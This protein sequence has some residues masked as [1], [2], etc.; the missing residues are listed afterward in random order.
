MQLKQKL[1]VRVKKLK[2]FTMDLVQ[3]E[4]KVK[5]T[6]ADGGKV[7]SDLP[8]LLVHSWSKL[9]A[10]HAFLAFDLAV[11]LTDAARALSNLARQ[12]KFQTLGKQR[13][14]MGTEVEVVMD[15]L[16]LVRGWGE[17]W[18]LLDAAE[19]DGTWRGAIAKNL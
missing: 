18:H 17:G 1:V 9:R 11:A 3:F 6:L 14:R 16:G 13:E 19:Y 10:Q 4:S 8:E 5:S 15:P 12:Y 7:I 2:A